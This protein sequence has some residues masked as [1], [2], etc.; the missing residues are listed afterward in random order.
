[1]VNYCCVARC[2]SSALETGISFHG[3]PKD[4]KMSKVSKHM[5]NILLHYLMISEVLYF[6]VGRFTC[7]KHLNVVEGGCGGGLSKV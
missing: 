1:M 3:F 6:T 4:E 5:Y 2:K 7:N